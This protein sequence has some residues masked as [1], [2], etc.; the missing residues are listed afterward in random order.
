MLCPRPTPAGFASNRYLEFNPQY[1]LT[2]TVAGVFRRLGGGKHTERGLA[3]YVDRWGC[4]V[5]MV[6]HV[7]KRRFETQIPVIP[8]GEELRQARTDCDRTGRL[9]SPDAGIA[10]RPALSGVWANALKLK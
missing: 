9:E 2:C 10:N 1:D 3:A 6:Q 5:G 8:D 7:G 4:V